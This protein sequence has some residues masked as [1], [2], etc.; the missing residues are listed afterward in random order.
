METRSINCSFETFDYE[1][2]EIG[3]VF[4]RECGG[5]GKSDATCYKGVYRQRGMGQSE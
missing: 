2:E 1:E 5:R 3:Q 4:L